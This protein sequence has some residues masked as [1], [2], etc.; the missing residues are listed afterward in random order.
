MS[1]KIVRMSE[2]ELV[3]LME[4]IVIEAVAKK[5]KEWIAENA[6]KE[7]NELLESRIND[8]EEKIIALTES[9]K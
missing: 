2:T 9:K 3:E 7:G 8:L 5:K 1:K 6:S 4:N